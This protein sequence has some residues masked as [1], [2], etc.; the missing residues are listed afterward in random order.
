MGDVNLPQPLRGIVVPMVTPL[1]GRDTLDVAGL[2]RLVEHLLAGGV[3]GLFVL[4]STGEGPSLS[5]RLRGELV[6]RVCRQVADRVPVLAGANDTALTECV[7]FAEAARAA[8]ASAVVLSTPS[9]YL[10]SQPELL[11]YYETIIPL[12]PP[13][14]F[15]YNMPSLTKLAIEPA[16]VRRL[17]DL[18]GVVGL[19]DTSRDMIYFHKVRRLLADRPD[20]ALLLGPEQ[21]LAE[22]LLMGAHGGVHTG[23]NIHPRLYVDLYEAATARDL[24]RV[25]DLQATAMQLTMSIYGDGR[26]SANIKGAKC[27]LSLMGVCSDTM[28]EPMRPFDDARRKQVRQALVELGLLEG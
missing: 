9:Y 17:A 1:T 23:T 28:A 7:E 10:V 5:R 12:L 21:L 18:P 8:G 24:D 20:F 2:E 26:H 16:T 11:A 6:E 15:L 19:K 25:N 13:P 27:A 22:G 14:V 4:G 3:N